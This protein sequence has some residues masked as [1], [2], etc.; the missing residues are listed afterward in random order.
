MSIERGMDKEDVVAI[1]SGILFSHKKNKIMPFAAIGRDFKIILSEV[2]ET[3]RDQYHTISYIWNI[4]KIIQ[5][6][7]FMK[8]KNS[9]IL[10]SN[11]YYYMGNCGG[12]GRN[13]GMGITYCCM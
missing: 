10:S 4:I 9:Q 3:E 5:K 7:L 1:Y 8:Q 13:W 12:G 11:L 2:N 6:N